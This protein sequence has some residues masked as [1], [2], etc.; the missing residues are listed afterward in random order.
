[1]D[2]AKA[3]EVAFN[4]KIEK[5]WEKIYVVVDIHDTILRAYYEN[6]ETY[7]YYPYSRESL[8]LMT[9]RED[10]CLI[11]WSGCYDDKMAASLN[12]HLMAIARLRASN[13]HSP[14]PLHRRVIS[15]LLMVFNMTSHASITF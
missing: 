13:D 6:E 2:I 14:T 11:L 5:N 4:R 15:L 3:F 10:I 12:L 8:Q 9:N 7:D 1:M